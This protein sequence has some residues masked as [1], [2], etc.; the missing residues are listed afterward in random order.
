[1]FEMINRHCAD[2]MQM[3][4]VGSGEAMPGEIREV[5]RK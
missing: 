3:M 1:M 5:F 4:N 2:T